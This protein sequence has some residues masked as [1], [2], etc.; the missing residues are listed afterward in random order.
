MFSIHNPKSKILGC[1]RLP[2]LTGIS[3]RYSERLGRK[4]KMIFKSSYLFDLRLL[5]YE[6]RIKDSQMMTTKIKIGLPLF[7]P[8][9]MRYSRLDD[10]GS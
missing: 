3:S 1:D 7:V 10:V 9:L 5:K 4:I 8:R 2:H 6:T